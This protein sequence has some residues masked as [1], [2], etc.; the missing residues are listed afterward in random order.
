[1]LLSINEEPD[2]LNFGEVRRTSEMASEDF[3][4]TEI[5]DIFDVSH[6]E[7]SM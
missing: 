6:H 3:D 7:D 2:D 4:Q 5:D 1:M